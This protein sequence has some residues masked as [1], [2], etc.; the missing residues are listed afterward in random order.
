MPEI[1]S[2]HAIFN[3]DNKSHAHLKKA[4]TEQNRGIYG[5]SFLDWLSSSVVARLRRNRITPSLVCGS[6]SPLEISIISPDFD[7]MYIPSK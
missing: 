3:L 4:R 7:G 5:R 1:F 6:R 2:L